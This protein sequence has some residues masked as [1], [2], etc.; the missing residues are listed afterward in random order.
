MQPITDR[1]ESLVGGRLFGYLHC[2]KTRPD[3]RLCARRK[4][5]PLQDVLAIVLC[6]GR[7]TRL[8]PL[9]KLRTKP[10]IPIGGRYRLIDIPISNCINSGIM[11]VFI[12]TQFLPASLHR[13]VHRTYQFDVFSGG[14]G[15]PP[16]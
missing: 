6:G 12:L 16:R 4:N 13:H 2:R 5:M 10:A 3:K 11:R 14:S 9:T 7:G 8:Y 1:E 15:D